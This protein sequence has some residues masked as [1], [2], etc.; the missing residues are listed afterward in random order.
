MIPSKMSIVT[1][2]RNLI[3]EEE[4]PAQKLNHLPRVIQCGSEGARM[5]LLVLALDAKPAAAL[6]SPGH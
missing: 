5:T 1:R 2:L 4:T 3:L 6:T